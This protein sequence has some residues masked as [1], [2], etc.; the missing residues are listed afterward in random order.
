VANV[1]GIGFEV[2]ELRRNEQELKRNRKQLDVFL[3]R[4]TEHICM[5]GPDRGII[6]VNARLCEFLGVHAPELAGRDVVDVVVPADRSRAVTLFDRLVLGE[7]EP[8]EVFDVQNASG[9]VRQIEVSGTLVRTG[10]S[11]DTV[12]IIGRDV[13]GRSSS[14]EAK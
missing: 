10:G 13:T 1:A 14:T 7:P 8:L 5:V 12:V 6:M 9:L 3:N 2:T 11:P 4:S